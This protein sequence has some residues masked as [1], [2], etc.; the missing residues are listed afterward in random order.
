MQENVILMT[1][2]AQVT[3][4][5]GDA[6]EPLFTT[7]CVDGYGYG[8]QGYGSG[9]QYGASSTSQNSSANNSWGQGQGGWSGSGQQQWGG[10]YSKQSWGG[11]GYSSSS[12]QR[13][14][15]KKADLPRSHRFTNTLVK[16]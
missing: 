14:V 2:A 10:S 12:G 1:T 9:Q 7:T 13:R 5:E 6:S 15:Q 4:R 3:T 8:S 11:S 16:Q